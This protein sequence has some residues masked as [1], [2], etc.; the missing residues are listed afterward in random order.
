MRKFA[1]LIRAAEQSGTTVIKLNIGDPDLPVPRAFLRTVAAQTDRVTLPYAPS[2]GLPEHVAA[3]LKYYRG[4]GVSLETNQVLPTTGGAEAIQMSLL[5]VADPGDEVLVFEPLYS[6]FKSAA[7]M[8][9]I[10]FVPVPLR[11]VTDFALPPNREIV[12]LITPKTRA[13]V[14]INPDNPTGKLWRRAE[15]DRLVALTV[16]HNLFL[17]SDET[18]REIVFRGRPTTMLRDRRA[19]ERLIV[20]DS[21]SKRFSMPG[22][23]LGAVVSRHPG[24]MKAATKFAMARLSSPTLEQL[25]SVPLLAAA[26][27]HTRNIAA[28]YRRRRDAV[29]EELAKL[30]GVSWHEP[31]GAFYIVIRLPVADS[32]QFVRFLIG[33]FRSHGETVMVTPMADFYMTPGAGRDEIRLAFVRPPA[34]LRRAVRLVGQALRQFVVS[35]L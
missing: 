25:G 9:N 33:R 1:P 32:E 29:T 35:S 11:L 22:A 26:G 31:G 14:V 3:W 6:G 24:A 17:I 4:L 20:V 10:R 30:P 12:R 34:V 8:F 16:K 28:E 2:T 15:L 18:Y 5:A 13:V 19:R 7:G 21:L 23:R 27:R